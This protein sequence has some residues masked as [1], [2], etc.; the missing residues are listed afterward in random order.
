M[1]KHVVNMTLRDER[2]SG[3]EG[4]ESRGEKMRERGRS[5]VERVY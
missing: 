4:K 5:S 3:E 2:G 1:R